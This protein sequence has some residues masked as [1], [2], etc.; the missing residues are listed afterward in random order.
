MKR[1]IFMLAC[2]MLTAICNNVIA[3][4]Y[5]D[6]EAHWAR[7][8]IEESIDNDIVNGYVDKTFRPNNSM[9]VA[10]YLKV[11]VNSGKFILIKEGDNLWPDYYISTAKENKLIFENEFEDFNKKINRNE[12]AKITARYIDVTDV[13]NARNKFIDL[14]KDYKSDILKLLKLGV[15]NGYEDNTYRGENAVTRAEAIVIA[16]RATIQRRKISNK[17]EY[18]ISKEINLSNIKSDI[19][20]KGIFKSTKYEIKDGEIY[21]YDDGR[22]S[23]L[24]GYKIS[25]ENINIKKVEKTIKSLVNKDGYTAVCY[26]PIKDMINK[27]VITY[28][29]NETQVHYGNINFNIIY[30]ENKP[31]ELRRI[32]K[33]E[34]FSEKCYMKFEVIKLWNNISDYNNGKFV[35]EYKKEKL[36]KCLEIEFGKKYASDILE[37][38]VDK[39]VKRV[40]RE[41]AEEDHAEVKRFGKY[42]INYYKKVGDVPQ[43]YIAIDE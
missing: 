21:I 16:Q 20:T 42:I 6:I 28:A 15:V 38:M 36:L 25:D 40:S 14:E 27:L 11:L 10:E 17:K 34:E 12:I 3:S 18:D 4:E 13:P 2:V 23:K 37:Y 32:S 9:T 39:N 26:I 30:F 33:R 43:F 19:T 41:S 8:I 22:Y 31:Y 7:E 5:T 29:E 35:D 1:I 24:Q